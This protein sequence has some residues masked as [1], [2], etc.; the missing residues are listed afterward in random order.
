MPG[1]DNI[2][3]KSGKGSTVL[4]KQARTGTTS[5]CQPQG[6]GLK[7]GVKYVVVGICGMVVTSQLTIMCTMTKRDW[8][9]EGNCQ[10]C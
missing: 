8:S 3:K 6:R 2:H 5:L 7:T 10:K 4:I 1:K 9:T